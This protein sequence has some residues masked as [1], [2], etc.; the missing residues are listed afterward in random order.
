MRSKL[1]DLLEK[2]IFFSCFASSH[3]WARAA[4]VF[5]VCRLIVSD[6]CAKQN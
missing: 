2:L 6:L 5:C 4:L 3:H 1:H